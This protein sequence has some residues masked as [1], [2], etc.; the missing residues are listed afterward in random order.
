MF[1]KKKIFLFIIIILVILGIA[2]FINKKM[3]KNKKSVNN[4]NSQEIVDYILNINSYKANA[5]VQINSNKNSNKYI[6]KQE[7][8]QNESIEEILEPSNIKGI[9]II[10]KEGNLIVEN[11]NLNLSTIFENYQILEENYLDL[12]TFI[13]ECKESNNYKY[14]E[15]NDSL[16]I[17]LKSNKDNK[18]IK[19]KILYINKSKAI[20][21]KLVIEDDNK[22]IQVNIEY[23]EIELN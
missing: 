17:K 14:E 8:N 9:K 6:L 18:Y 1:K 12:S 19:N 23:N 5:I 21:T 10:N 13:N 16:I 20:P 3:T 4:M 15:E 22:K 11:S 7:Y 2:L